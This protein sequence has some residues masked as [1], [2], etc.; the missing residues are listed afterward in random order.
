MIKMIATPSEILYF[1]RQ[2][3]GGKDLV[4]NGIA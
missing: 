3:L 1:P 4:T 2:E